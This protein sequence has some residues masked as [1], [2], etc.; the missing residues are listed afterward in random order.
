MLPDDD[1]DHHALMGI[2]RAWNRAPAHVREEFLELA[3]EANL[4]VIDA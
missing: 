1:W 2:T 3:G 4:G